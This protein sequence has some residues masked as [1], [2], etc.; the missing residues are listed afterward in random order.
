MQVNNQDTLAVAMHS[1]DQ[2]SCSRLRAGVQKYLAIMD[3]YWKGSV[4]PDRDFQRL[5]NGYYRIRQRSPTWYAQYFRML[6]QLKVTNRSFGEILQELH[7]HTGRLEA[8]FASK[9]L[10]TRNP[11]LPVID[12]WVLDNLR[13][14]LPR[15]GE[16]D[17]IQKVSRLYERIV[18]WYREFLTVPAGKRALRMFDDLIP[19]CDVTPVK[20]IDF[21]LWQT[22]GSTKIAS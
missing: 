15:Y 12:R 6:E 17:K 19:R 13:L 4:A 22:R 8:S 1:L 10:A 21:I 11:E 2:A 16:K 5:F 7:Q 18:A 20:K 3:R 14:H 9:M